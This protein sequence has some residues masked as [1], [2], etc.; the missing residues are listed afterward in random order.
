MDG[1][2]S[3][4]VFEQYSHWPVED[5]LKEVKMSFGAVQPLEGEKKQS[6]A[7]V[8]DTSKWPHGVCM[9]INNEDFSKHSNREGTNL[10][11]CNVVQTFR[12]LGYLVEVHRDCNAAKMR[13]IFE[14]VR[15]RDHSQYDSFVCCIMSHGNAGHIYSSDSKRLPLDAIADGFKGD[16]C[17]SL[18]S[19]PKMFFMQ[20]CRGLNKDKAVRVAQDSG[21]EASAMVADPEQVVS[22]SEGE[23]IPDAADFFFSYA[24]P[25]NHVAWRDLDNGSWYVSEL[26]TS[27]TSYGTFSSLVD[28]VTRTNG[29]VAAKY[30]VRGFKQQ[31][32]LTSRL[33]KDVFFF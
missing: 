9:V 6:I 1:S 11:E 30:S 27:L 4:I 17:S 2:N 3:K 24:T 14:E 18:A 10:D 13:D 20:A 23:V 5:R 32:D 15:K 7:G 8:Y 29:Q 26:C 16:R 19:K 28:M 12:H 22:D 25:L 31:P 33:R 21:E